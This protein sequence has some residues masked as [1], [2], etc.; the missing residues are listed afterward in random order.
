[1][2]KAT[3]DAKAL[4]W[5]TP[6][7]FTSPNYRGFQRAVGAAGANAIR[8]NR[9]PHVVN[10]SSVGAHIGHDTGLI[11]GLHD[12]EELIDS[13]AINVTHLR[14]AAFMENFLSSAKTIKASNLI[15]R[16]VSG[17]TRLPSIAIRDVAK[18]AAERLLN[19]T[20][21]GHQVLTL[22]GPEE[23]TFDEAAEKISHVLGRTVRH[24]SISPK[25]AR[26]ALINMGLSSDMASQFIEMYQFFE[27]APLSRELPK[28]PD[29]RTATTFEQ[30]VKE[31]LQ[32]A[33]AG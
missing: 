23:L 31:V 3:R 27:N 26:Q 18:V 1:M 20:W 4:F 2:E 14:P 21:T 10:L 30:F 7:N 11:N 24:V 15:F 5:V 29:I 33:I 12:V 6:T 13:A 9:I 28:A 25:M 8:A 32:P 19:P 22:Y 17:K 16:P